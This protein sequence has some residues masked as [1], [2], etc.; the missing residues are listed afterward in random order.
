M[1]AGASGATST[2]F[3]NSVIANNIFYG[4]VQYLLTE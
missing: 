4:N 2:V 3:D 1:V